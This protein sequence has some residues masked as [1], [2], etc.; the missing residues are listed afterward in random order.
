M[1][2][3]HDQLLPVLRWLFGR[4]GDGARAVAHPPEVD[5]RA[6]MLLLDTIGCMLAGLDAAPVAQFARDLALVAPGAFPLP[7]GTRLAPLAAA[8]ALAVAAPWDEACEGLA[9]AHGRP[10]VPVVAAV[11]ALGHARGSTLGGAL[12]AIVTGY[13]IGGRMGEWLRI[14]PGMHV[15]AGFGAFGV[16]AA[17][18][19]LAGQSAD[20]AL[21]AIETVGCQLPFGLYAP[22]RAGATARNTYLAHATALGM[23]AAQAIHAGIDAPADALD[24]HARIA[25]GIDPATARIAPA[26]EHLILEGYLKPFAAVRHVHYGAAAALA[27][28]DAVLTRMGEIDRIA[29]AVYEEA[30]RYCGNRAPATPIAAQFSLAFGVAAALR[31]GELGPAVYRDRRFHETGLRRLEALVEVTVDDALGAD[32]GRGARLTLH[33]GGD[34]WSTTVTSV[35]GDRATPFTATECREKFEAYAGPVVGSARARALADTVLDGG[36]ES[37]LADLWNPTA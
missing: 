18:A 15:D 34:S 23:M 21:A 24:D 13:E 32:G 25:L 20:D 7:D 4:R 36:P 12:D 22:V 26:G 17:C 30:T 1:P 11:L 9:R 29:L 2:T 3:A 5:A 10:G 37:N 16:A 14:R 8:Q 27:L 35:K 31:F 6:R 33:A 19:H 28:R